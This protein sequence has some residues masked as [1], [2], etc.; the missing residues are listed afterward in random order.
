MEWE[1]DNAMGIMNSHTHF[2][3]IPCTM[4]VDREIKTATC[5]I[6]PKQYQEYMHTYITKQFISSVENE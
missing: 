1:K 4:K 6:K 5:M 2:H 3:I